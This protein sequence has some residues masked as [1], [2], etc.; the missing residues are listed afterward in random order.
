MLSC[1]PRAV[2]EARRC[3]LE[4]TAVGNK[5]LDWPLLRGSAGWATGRFALAAPT[6]RRVALFWPRLSACV[7]NIAKWVGYA[8]QYVGLDLEVGLRC[9]CPGPACSG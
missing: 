3:A 7:H 8:S 2:A 1:R 6:E 9:F 4:T 5:P